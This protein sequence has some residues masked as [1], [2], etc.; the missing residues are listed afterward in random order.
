MLKGFAIFVFMIALFSAKTQPRADY[1][2]MGGYQTDAVSGAL[3]GHKY[4]FASSP[5]SITAQKMPY[6]IAGRSNASI[7]DTEGRLLFYTNGQG[8]V[9]RNMMLMPHGR[10]INDGEWARRFWPDATLGY[11]GPQDILI[12]PD[13]ASES[14]YYLIH[15]TPVYYADGYDSIEIRMSYVD[16]TLDGGLGDVVFKNLYFYTGQDLLFSYL[17]AIRHQNKRDWWILQPTHSRAVKTFLLD[18]G[19]IKSMPDQDSGVIFTNEAGTARFSPDGTKYAFYNEV[20]NLLIYDFDRSTG[21]LTLTDHV[22][23]I[24][25][26]GAYIFSSVEWSPNSRYIYTV[27][28]WYLYQVDTRETDPAK[29]VRLI[30]TYNGTKDPYSTD[31]FLMAQGPDCRIYLTPGAGTYSIHVI[32]KPDEPGKACDFVQNGIKLP[33]SNGG[34][35]PNFPRFRVDEAEKCNPGIT[36]VFGHEVYYRRDLEAYPNPATDHITIR[37]PVTVTSGRLVVADVYGRPLIEESFGHTGPPG[38][39]DVSHLPPASYHIEIY[40]DDNPD[41]IY[42]GTQIVKL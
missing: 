11:P 40:P 15:K 30:D 12:L 25:T 10:G 27:I 16:M 42:Y 21:R 41:R 24:D 28:N 9:N 14:G 13:P 4:D 23:P 33:N 36:S 17:T 22:V 19:G 34:T 7:C 2:W 38:R 3:V 6:G 5:P 39:V 29:K 18:P 20:N 31:F 1:I 8:V 35:L 32:N 37:L 26:T